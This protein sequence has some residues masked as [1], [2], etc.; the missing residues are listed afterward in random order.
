MDNSAGNTHRALVQ[1]KARPGRFSGKLIIARKTLKAAL[2]RNSFTLIDHGNYAGETGF[3]A[4]LAAMMTEPQTDEALMLL[5]C[6]GDLSAFKELYQRHRLGLYRFIDWRSPRQ[7]WVDEIVQDSWAALH[8]ARS[9]YTPLAGFKTYLYQIARN[10]LIDI[11]R[12]RE[13]L[14][15]SDPDHYEHTLESTQES[16][17][18]TRSPET[19][20][21]KKQQTERL[22]EAIR[23][24]PGEQ[25]EALVL[26][27]FNGLSLEEIAAITAV[28]TETVKS[29]LRYA[30]QKLRAE[31]HTQKQGE[32]A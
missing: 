23:T 13:S 7:E 14:L 9:Q 8:A 5:Y 22:H 6:D 20:L 15:D 11:L 30:M 24:L 29:R 27:Q 16:T 4:K 12:Q 18:L 2:L 31:L 21:E 1:G 17:P 19:R 26:Q 10:R 32:P 3:S 28:S 25:K